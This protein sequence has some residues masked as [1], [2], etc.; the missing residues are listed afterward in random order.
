MQSRS[1]PVSPS[2]EAVSEL[3]LPATLL[4][5]LMLLS[6]FESDAVWSYNPSHP[7]GIESR[8]RAQLKHDPNQVLNG[9]EQRR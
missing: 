7:V 4:L 6:I 5:W 8:S 1:A 9:R 3:P 2:N